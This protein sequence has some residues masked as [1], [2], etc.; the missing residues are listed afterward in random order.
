MNAFHLFKAELLWL[1][2]LCLLPF[3]CYGVKQFSYPG[4]EDWPKD[5]VSDILRWG[6][7]ALAALTLASLVFAA[8]GPFTEGG[9]VT[10][11]GKGAEIVIVLDR[12]GSMSESLEEQ[13]PVERARG[14]MELSRIEAS[15]KALLRLMDERPGDTFAVVAFN[16]SPIAV[17]PFS[18]DRELARAALKSAEGNS[19]GFTALHRAL[20]MGLDY[21]KDRPYTATRVI[22]LVSDGDTKIKPEDEEIL[23]QRFKEYQAQ[24]MWI[25]VHE[26]YDYSLGYEEDVTKDDGAVDPNV[27]LN[28]LFN[29]LGMPYQA[30]E[31]NSEMGLQRAAAEIGRATNKE[32][33]YQY[34]LPRQDYAVYFYLLSM[35]L[36]GVLFFLKQIEIKSWRQA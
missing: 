4:L 13:D 12:S 20:E 19:S 8:A 14:K 34:R 6:V 33:R 18:A 36:L 16:A 15:R 26:G 27:T 11:I 22:L 21:F 31:V 2:P 1:L 7:R 30:F 24:L 23:R 28:R 5:S 25:Y 32:T 35:V 29:S 9:T 3:L 10:K 17:A